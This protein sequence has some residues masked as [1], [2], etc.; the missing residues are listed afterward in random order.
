MARL[1]VCEYEGIIDGHNDDFYISNVDEV[2]P[3]T[4]P[5]E[6]RHTYNAE[7]VYLVYRMDD[8]LKDY[9]EVSPCHDRLLLAREHSKTLE[10][11]G[12]LLEHKLCM[13]SV[14]MGRI[15]L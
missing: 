2:W 1:V 8:V 6:D 3:D 5:E 11:L 7:R 14:N 9:L 12:Y 10:P 4:L 13:N 15:R